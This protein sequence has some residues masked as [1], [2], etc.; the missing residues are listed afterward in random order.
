VG[1]SGYNVSGCFFLYSKNFVIL[2]GFTYWT[3]DGG[4][5]IDGGEGSIDLVFSDSVPYS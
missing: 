2:T 3:I 4:Y 5:N 1:A